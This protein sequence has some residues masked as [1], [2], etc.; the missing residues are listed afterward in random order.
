[1]V[2]AQKG[3][4]Y[5]DPGPDPDPK[6]NKALYPGF[7]TLVES[8]FSWVYYWSLKDHVDGWL[9][10]ALL[11]DGHLHQVIHLHAAPQLRHR[12]HLQTGIH[13]TGKEVQDPT[14]L[15]IDW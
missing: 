10:G 15:L 14:Y 13:V 9:G 8:M 2:E 3:M 5:P 11:N 7:V 12:L 6:V 1:M 4:F